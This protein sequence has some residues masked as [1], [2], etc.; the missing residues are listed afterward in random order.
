MFNL[1]KGLIFNGDLAKN[2]APDCI[3]NKRL[4]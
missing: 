4:Y 3:Y 2:K 1:F